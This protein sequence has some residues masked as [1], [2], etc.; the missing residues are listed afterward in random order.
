MLMQ[1]KR[2]HNSYYQ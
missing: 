2:K 1:D